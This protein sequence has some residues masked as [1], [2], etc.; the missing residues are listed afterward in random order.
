[1]NRSLS[2]AAIEVERDSVDLKH[3]PDLAD[4]LRWLRE[5]QALDAP[6][7]LVVSGSWVWSN[8]SSAVD[9]LTR[10]PAKELDTVIVPR[11]RPGKWLSLLR[12]PAEI[13]AVAG[14][15]RSFE[16]GADHYG[17]PGFTVFRTSLHA[18]KWAEAAAPGPGSC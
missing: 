2:C 4:R 14:E 8:F 15:F 16:W 11:H 5:D 7:V 18:G 3:L 13:E 6:E 10:R 9:V 17:V 12:T 1:M